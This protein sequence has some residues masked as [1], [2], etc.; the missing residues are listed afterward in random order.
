MKYRFAIVMAT[1]YRSNGNTLK[2]L[3]RSIDSI[4]GQTYK[5]WDLIVVDD[6]YDVNHMSELLEL[7]ESY[8]NKINNKVI[9]LHN[10]MPERDFL[11]DKIKLY[12]CAG[13]RS[14][15]IGLNYAR[16]NNYQLYAHIDDDD[17]WSSLHLE[18]LASA[19]IEYPMCVFANTKSTYFNSTLPHDSEDSKCL[20]I[21]PNNR[22]PLACK[23]IHSSFS[24]RCDIISYDYFT[25]INPMDFFWYSDAIM[26]SRIKNFIEKN[27]DYCSIYI[28]TLTCYHDYEGEALTL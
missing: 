16:A 2:Y 15:N 3:K 8:R 23:T 13:A 19:Y 26:L 10:N 17:F 14:M 5:E 12:S 18:K 9:H 24:F 27:S 25:S 1:F 22:L 20:P 21:Q 7:L 6:K 4:V 28:P 11:K